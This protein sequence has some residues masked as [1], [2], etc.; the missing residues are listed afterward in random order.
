MTDQKTAKQYSHPITQGLSM[1]QRNLTELHLQTTF[2]AFALF[3]HG[4]SFQ[5]H[6]CQNSFTQNFANL[7]FQNEAGG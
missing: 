4:Y 3:V 5:L 7:Q 1:G 2:S 6:C